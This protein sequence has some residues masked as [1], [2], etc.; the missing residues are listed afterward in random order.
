LP[1]ALLPL[2]PE[3]PLALVPPLPEEPPAPLPP[4][5]SDEPP[6]A[7][8]PPLGPAHDGDIAAVKRNPTT[9][10]ATNELLLLITDA[11]L[12]AN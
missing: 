5:C 1:P 12:V 10:A 8:L 4:L 7:P 9:L 3:P 2:D 6:L 11:P